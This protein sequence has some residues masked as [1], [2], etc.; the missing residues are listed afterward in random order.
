MHILKIIIKGR[1]SL[2]ILYECHVFSFVPIALVLTVGTSVKSLAIHSICT[3]L[4]NV[5]T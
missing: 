4:R 1:K 2:L 5:Y 3:T